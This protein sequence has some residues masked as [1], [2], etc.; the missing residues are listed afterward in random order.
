MSGS[1][2][3]SS[4][5]SR[6]IY[7]SAI[8]TPLAPLTDEDAAIFRA[9]VARSPMEAGYRIGHST[10]YDRADREYMLG[11][12]IDRASDDAAHEADM[13]ALRREQLRADVGDESSSSSLPL[14][15]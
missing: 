11:R 15:K 5:D 4:A 12:M 6:A 14:E 1:N 10:R 9:Q 7:N 8:R 3:S 2:P 13:R